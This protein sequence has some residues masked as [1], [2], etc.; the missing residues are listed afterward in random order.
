MKMKKRS[1]RSPM[2]KRKRKRKS[3]NRSSIPKPASTPVETST[4]P[5]TASIPA[6]STPIEMSTTP[7]EKST[8]LASIPPGMS[9]SPI[10]TSTS[11]GMSTPL[12]VGFIPLATLTLFLQLPYSSLA[13]TS[14]HSLASSSAGMSSKLVPSSSVRPPVPALQP[15]H[16]PVPS[17]QGVVDSRILILST[18][19]RRGIDET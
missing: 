9:V 19:D 2:K 5:A 14:T 12:S 10:A 3:L 7:V 8:T 16:S 18:A 15:A 11:P 1:N 6:A 17:S 13:P 4:T